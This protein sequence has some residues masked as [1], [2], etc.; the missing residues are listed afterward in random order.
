[1]DGKLLVGCYAANNQ[2]QIWDI[3]KHTKTEIDWAGNKD[4]AEYIY[5]A[6]YSRRDPSIFGA[7]STGKQSEFR[8]YQKSS[9]NEDW[10]IITKINNIS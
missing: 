3:K 5:A 1:M 7:G 9:L 10:H 4:D 8:L 2:I 6:G